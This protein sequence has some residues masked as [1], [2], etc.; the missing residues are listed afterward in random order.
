M[1]D[2]ISPTQPITPGPLVTSSDENSR[3][4]QRQKQ[5][6]KKI[7]KPVPPAKPDDNKGSYIDEYV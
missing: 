3:Q 4:Q 5:Q 1:A 2:D 6:P 7:E